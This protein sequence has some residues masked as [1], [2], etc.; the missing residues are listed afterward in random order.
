MLKDLKRYSSIG[1]KAGILTFCERMLTGEYE[2]ISSQKTICAYTNGISL[3][4]DCALLAFIHLGLLNKTDQ[5]AQSTTLIYQEEKRDDIIQVICENCYKSLIKD[6]LIKINKISFDEEKNQYS[7][8]KSAFSLDAAVFR[9]ML[10]TLDAMTTSNGLFFIPKSY[11]GI[12]EKYI[13]E[14]RK[15]IS[16][17]ELQEQ[18]ERQNEIGEAGE[19]FALKFEQE[20]LKASGINHQARRISLVDVRAG[21]D[22]ASFETCDSIHYDRFIEVKTYSGKQEFH[23]S[24]NEIEIA[25]LRRD[26]Y[27]LY[28]VD[29]SRINDPQYK[30][31][32]IS[33]P[34]A[35]IVEQ[36]LWKMNP[37]SW[38]VTIED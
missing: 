28:I 27:L 34:Y 22:I 7:L 15:K 13:V 4:F 21:Y 1:N 19:L 25:R 30:P 23:W 3:N 29:Y 8:K 24:K 9:N 36:K 16:L 38:V 10:I 2:N 14:E 26:S 31:K 37:E 20:R 12:F 11:D 6:G 17:L 32:I 18:L 5:Q 33:N 35:M